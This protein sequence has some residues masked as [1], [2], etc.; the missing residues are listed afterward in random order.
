MNSDNFEIVKD[1]MKKLLN[2]IIKYHFYMKNN[3]INFRGTSD[4]ITYDNLIQQFDQIFKKD[5]QI[6]NNFDSILD[7]IDIN[8]NS[9]LIGSLNLINEI[10]NNNLCIYTDE[11]NLS[12]S[13]YDY[14]YDFK[15]P[16]NNESKKFDDIAEQLKKLAEQQ[17]TP[18]RPRSSRQGYSQTST[19]QESAQP[20]WPR[21]LEEQGRRQYHTKYHTKMK[22]MKYKIKYYKL[23]NKIKEN[24]I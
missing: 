7:I 21:V 11:Q 10:Q 6:F 8:N 22:Y 20:K 15:E 5:E 13:F 23:K 1:K 18:Q 4:S 16:K 19:S 12:H 24:I 3:Y 14:S 17:N 9:T 2:K